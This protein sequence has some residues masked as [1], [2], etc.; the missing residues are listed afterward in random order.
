[1][2]RVAPLIVMVTLRLYEVGPKVQAM[3]PELDPRGS[4]HK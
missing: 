1:M 3:N 4:E 2:R